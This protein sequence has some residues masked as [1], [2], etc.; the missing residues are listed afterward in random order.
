M[1][2]DPRIAPH[3]ALATAPDPALFAV[4]HIAAAL[5]NAS[6]GTEAIAACA[7]D[8]VGWP[9]APAREAIEL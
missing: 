7:L 1:G 9:G 6:P 2:A 4:R 5:N 3:P 8:T